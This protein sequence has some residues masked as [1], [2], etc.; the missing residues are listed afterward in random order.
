[1]KYDVMTP[2]GGGDSSGTAAGKKKT[3]WHKIG[4]GWSDNEDKITIV[5][6]SVPFR[7]E[8]IYLFKAKDQEPSRDQERSR[9]PDPAGDFE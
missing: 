7:S 8:Y 9:Y 4:R 1:M 5:L 6:D 3:R 2:I